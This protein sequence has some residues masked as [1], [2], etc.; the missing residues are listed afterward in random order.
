MTPG[1]LFILCYPPPSRAI[2][3]S[4]I[5]RSR[6]ESAQGFLPSASLHLIILGW[7]AKNRG[8]E[9]LTPADQVKL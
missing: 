6:A 7:W 8:G 9:A 2:A 1:G 4:V 5:P 3:L